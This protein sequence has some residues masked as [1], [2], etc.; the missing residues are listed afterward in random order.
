MRNYRPAIVELCNDL[1]VTGEDLAYSVLSGSPSVM[2]EGDA[3][4]LVLWLR[5]NANDVWGYDARHD[6]LADRIE[7][8]V[9]E[10]GAA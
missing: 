3:L 6:A 2:T 1:S 4:G 7:R 5:D 8:L 9:A 10:G